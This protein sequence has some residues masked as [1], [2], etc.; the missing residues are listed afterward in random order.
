MAHSENSRKQLMNENSATDLGRLWYGSVWEESIK[1]GRRERCEVEM[2]K[3]GRESKT[4]LVENAH[5]S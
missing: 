5:I 4:F 1:V 2:T 3:G